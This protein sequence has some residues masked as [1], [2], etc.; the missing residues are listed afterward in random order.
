[1]DKKKKQLKMSFGERCKLAWEI[2][3]H[4]LISGGKEITTV[5]KINEASRVR[6]ANYDKRL[7][8][9]IIVLRQAMLNATNIETSCRSDA[10][11]LVL[12]IGR[13]KLRSL[14]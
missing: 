5:D 3:L 10:N 12:Q 9:V 4:G 8:N 14:P 2:L 7:K 1:M 13:Y 11:M 6:L